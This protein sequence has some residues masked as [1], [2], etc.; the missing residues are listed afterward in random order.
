MI[1]LE[2]RGKHLRIRVRR[3][4]KG[5]V[6]RT[7]DVGSPKHTQ[8]IAMKPRGRP[9]VTQSWIFPLKDVQTRRRQTMKVLAGLG[10]QK[11]A[12]KMVDSYFKRRGGKV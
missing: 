11:R 8:R 1:P 4:V 9:W 6:F 5:A 12:I 10:V 2:I 7:H 3:S